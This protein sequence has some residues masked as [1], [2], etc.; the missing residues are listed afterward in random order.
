MGDQLGALGYKAGP[1]AALG[2][3]SEQFLATSATD[4]EQRLE[5]TRV[6]QRDHRPVR[7]VGQPRG[8]ERLIGHA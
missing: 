8:P 5:G 3:E 7:A 4:R 1:H 6:D 2:D